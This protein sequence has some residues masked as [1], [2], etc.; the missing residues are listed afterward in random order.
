MVVGKGAS[1]EVSGRRHTGNMSEQQYEELQLS[2]SAV[3]DHSR[4]ESDAAQDHRAEIALLSREKDVLTKLIEEREMYNCLISDLRRLRQVHKYMDKSGGGGGATRNPR[5]EELK[6]E[7][8]KLHL[9]YQEYDKMD[10]SADFEMINMQ[11]Q[12]SN[13]TSEVSALQRALETSRID[14][15]REEL[16]SLEEEMAQLRHSVMQDRIKH[17]QLQ[18]RLAHR[19]MERMQE[20]KQSEVRESSEEEKGVLGCWERE[21]EERRALESVQRKRYDE[22]LSRIRERRSAYSSGTSQ[23]NKDNY[24]YDPDYDSLKTKSRFPRRQLP[25]KSHSLDSGYQEDHQINHP[26]H[27][28]ESP[29]FFQVP[30]KREHS[31]SEQLTNN[32][33]ISEDRKSSKIIEAL[34]S[35]TPA[36]NIENKVEVCELYQRGERCKF[37][38]DHFKAADNEK[39]HVIM[40]HIC[41]RCY[42]NL[43]QQ[44]R[45]PMESKNCHA[46]VHGYSSSGSPASKAAAE[47]LQSEEQL[48]RPAS[49][50]AT[51][52]SAVPTH[53]SR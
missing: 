2:K 48:P 50:S 14:V 12:L 49:S 15:L 39:G 34:S 13:L 9:I 46:R 53:V 26:N 33:P 5:I 42:R 20:L 38:G 10:K 28:N 27:R 8:H 31:K 37:S 51:S 16:K 30:E 6:A 41:A 44:N 43:G 40:R 45:H 35:A 18:H 32:Q 29:K 22:D 52:L 17:A 4:P 23:Q 25:I 24:D 11:H 21:E 36:N 47:Q 19:H 1:Y 3:K 7:V